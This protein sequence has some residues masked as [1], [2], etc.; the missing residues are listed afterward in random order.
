MRERLALGF[1]LPIRHTSLR[2]PDES[3]SRSGPGDLDALVRWTAIRPK[4][5]GDFQL[6]LVAGASLPTGD[7]VADLAID[8]NIRFGAGTTSLLAA[9]EALRGVGIATLYARAEAREPLGT[10][11]SGVDYGATTTVAAGVDIAAAD[12]AGV[13]V[14]AIWQHQGI[15]RVAGDPVP[16]RGGTWTYAAV[17]AR[18]G[19]TRRTQGSVLVQR[20]IA[21]DV[22][23]EQL[24]A[25]WSALI[26]IS[27]RNR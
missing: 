23:G 7:E 6:R 24:A 19:L 4:L 11:D 14:Q 25:P 27:F 1:A 16:S 10:S 15:D 20:L 5:P 12:R 22:R 18:T 3:L 21:A 9:V 26:G 2:G 17:G 8:E 13:L